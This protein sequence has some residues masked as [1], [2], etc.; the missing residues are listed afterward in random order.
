MAM[1]AKLCYFQLVSRSQQVRAD[2]DE[3]VLHLPLAADAEL[4]AV[5]ALDRLLARHQV[6]RQAAGQAR[7][8]LVEACLNAIEYAEP[9]QAAAVD[10]RLAIRGD[11]LKMSVAN[12][13]TPFQPLAAT[14]SKDGRGHGLK[15]IR[16]FMD[17]VRYLDD[18]GGTRL[19]MSKRVP[20]LGGAHS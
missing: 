9:A 6:E 8:A 13:G 10:V 19:E 15:I 14:A 20:C 18:A 1:A 5:D 17:R 3:V 2:T 4:R 12:P 16:A 7:F 11:E